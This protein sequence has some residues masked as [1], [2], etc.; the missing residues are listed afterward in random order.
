MTRLPNEIPTGAR[1]VVR[2]CDGIDPSDNR[3]K[4]RDYVGHV[5]SWDGETLDMMRDATPDG[6]RPGQRVKINAD[7]VVTLKPVPERRF[8]QPA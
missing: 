6:R 5:L 4:F 3:M 7:S 2:T 8:P 1:I